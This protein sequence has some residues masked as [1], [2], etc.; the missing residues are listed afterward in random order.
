MMLIFLRHG[1]T[2]YNRAGRWQG[3]IDSPLTDKGREQARSAAELLASVTVRDIVCSPLGRALD[4]AIIV[5]HR[6]EMPV[7][8]DVRLQEVGSGV[9]EGLTHE[10][11]ESRWPGFIAWRAVDRWSRA[12][13]GGETYGAARKRLMAFADA[14]GLAREI[15]TKDP[16]LLIVGHSRSLAILA[17]AMLGWTD[18][19]I[20][21]THPA[22]ATPLLVADGAFAPL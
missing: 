18:K 20:V 2:T 5:G 4:T 19:R 8:T 11:I 6:L 1:E 22:N 14:E 17:G 7:R 10:Q 12:P 15:D 16:A 9:C 21:E 3:Q 13:D